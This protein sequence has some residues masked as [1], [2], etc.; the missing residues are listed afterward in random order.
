M[1]NKFLK[2]GAMVSLLLLIVFIFLATNIWGVDGGIYFDEKIISSVHE[3]INPS[4]KGFMVLLSFLGSAK[5]Y[6]ILAPFLILYLVKKK[7]IIEL[8]A[9]LISILGSY[10]LN[11]L[12]KLFF[13]RHRPYEYFLVQQKGFSFPSGHAMIT[14]SF[15]AMAAYLYLRN[16]ELNLKKSLIWLVTIV[17]IGLVG[18]SRIYLGVHW[19][20]DIVAGFSAG[21]IWLYLC[22]LGV[23][24]T[25][26]RRYKKLQT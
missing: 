6:F 24:S 23:E 1:K 13:G 7:H 20:T 8:Y 9:L 14:L 5:F 12:L 4:I 11:E 22:I 10:G 2:I 26:K 18:F 21:Y 16:K 19:P 25:H 17:F 15:Y 3:N